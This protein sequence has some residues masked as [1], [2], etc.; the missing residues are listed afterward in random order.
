MTK[1]A[2]MQYGYDNVTGDDGDTVFQNGA[3]IGGYTTTDATF[4]YRTDRGPWGLKGWSASVDINNLFNVHKII[5][6]A[7]T[8]SVSGDPLW[9][10]LPGRGVFLDL[11]LKL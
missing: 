1:Y 11:S 7:G 5:G 9:W 8:Q 6:Y 2:G 3:H 4:G 10:G